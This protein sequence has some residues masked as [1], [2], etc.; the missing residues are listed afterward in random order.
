ME[1]VFKMTPTLW[2]D[3]NYGYWSNGSLGDLSDGSLR[4]GT[5]KFGHLDLDGY[6]HVCRS[7]EEHSSCKDRN[8]NGRSF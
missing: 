3:G 7:W 6:I 2:S 8:F 5:Y 4:N 1:G